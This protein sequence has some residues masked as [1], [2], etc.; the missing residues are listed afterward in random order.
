MSLI[1]RCA[2]RLARFS[3]LIAHPRL[4]GPRMRGALVS[5]IVALDQPWLRQLNPKTILDIGAN[6][7][8]FAVAINTIFPDARILSFEP[9]PDCFEQLKRNMAGATNFTAFNYGLGDKT[10]ELPFERN[11]FSMSSSFL[12]MTRTHTEAFPQTAQSSTVQVKV[13]RLDDVAAS[14]SIAQPFL[15]K[16]DV[17][18]YE[19]R[20]LHG[21]EQ[22]LR[23]A[24]AMLVEMSF[25][26]L[27][28]RQPLF[29][30]ICQQV[31]ELGF[32]YRGNLEQM[33]CPKTGR[34]LQVNGIFVRRQ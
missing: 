26:E 3:Y 33:N 2:E 13:E 8:Q 17:Q 34:V 18:G 15:A 27:Y 12:K 7:G 28:E 24:A 22:T 4:I 1:V 9:L 10:G 20:V 29:D 21:G 6:T 16:I 25:E 14:L 11:A 30:S 31:Q 32:A 19:D 23:R 5:T